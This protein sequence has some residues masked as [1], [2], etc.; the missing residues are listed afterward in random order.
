MSEWSNICV[1]SY[2]LK[3]GT[4][5]MASQYVSYTVQATCDGQNH[6]VERRFNEFSLLHKEMAKQYPAAIIAPLPKDQVFGRFKPAFI[7][8]RMRGLE[9]CLRKTYADP[10]MSKSC[11]WQP[12]FT[13]MNFN[14]G[15]VN[16]AK[17]KSG[18]GTQ[19]RSSW[20]DTMKNLAAVQ[21]TKPNVDT[22]EVDA[23]MKTITDYLDSY[24]SA[25]KRISQAAGSLANESIEDAKT[26]EEL[27]SNSK[28]LGEKVLIARGVEVDPEATVFIQFGVAL[29]A[30]AVQLNTN[31][32]NKLVRVKE[33]IEQYS[34]TLLS[35][36]AALNRQN[37][38]KKAYI[39][40]SANR[41]MAENALAKEPHAMDKIS[42]AELT[43]EEL[44]A[45]EA[46]FHSTSKALVE[47]F[48]K[49]K[50]SRVYEIV[51]ICESLVELELETCRGS[52][53]VLADLLDDL[54]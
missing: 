50:Q 27:S 28:L 26:L 53:D 13:A 49:I 42:K 14:E 5:V 33:P 38:V 37:E 40:A 25:M 17:C 9:E 15:A 24:T 11:L 8:S 39:A 6:T 7:E 34:R 32:R 30:M 45:A 18:A 3:K 19:R 36:K 23:E 31:S 44:E 12:F 4:D 1:S 51:Q 43:K 16:D 54:S 41:I 22:S 21:I 2:L 29:I 20:I 35:I 10:E 52:R 46:E 48:E 47:N